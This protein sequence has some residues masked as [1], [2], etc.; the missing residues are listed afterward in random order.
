MANDKVQLFENQPI[1]TAWVEDEEEWYFSV[2]D[3]VGV[4]TEQPD[5]D[6]ARNYWKVL[7]NRL[8][9][10]GSQLVTNCNQ[11]KMRSPKDGKRYNTDVASTEQL[12]RLI[13]SIPS[14]KAEPFKLWLAQVGRE[15]IEEVIDPESFEENRKVAIIG[16]EA[17]GEARLAVEKRTGKPVI[18]N[19]NAAQLQ[20]LVTGLIE[21]VN[22]KQKKYII[23]NMRKSEIS[24]LKDF[25]YE[26][27]FIPEGVEPPE[28]DIVERPELRVYTDDFGSRKGDN[29]LVADFGGKV[30][31]A[32]WT[33][34]M[35]DYGHV[36]DETPSFAISLYKE[37][38]GQGVGSQLMVK[39]LE[40][41]KRQGYEKASLAV[42]KANYAVK[43]YK[44][45]G[46]KTV[47]E[48]DEEYIMVC[49]L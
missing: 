17:A 24:L 20:D 46:F 42:Q 21:T 37:Y 29:C 13:Q 23:R 28:R 34:I 10:E 18:T 48:N 3:V 45:V 26:A 1:R 49:E 41:L 43:M 19:K 8:K 31:G 14:K 30:V 5:I 33:R 25:L 22:D 38:R 2:V 9:E 36:D 47:D 44:N 6:G 15:R 39:M 16:G 27:I 11:L 12:L 35:D 32:V 40:L 7:K 4:L